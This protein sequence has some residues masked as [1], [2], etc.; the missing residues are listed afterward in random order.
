MDKDCI[1]V[2]LSSPFKEITG[3]R[4]W[5]LPTEGPLTVEQIL[6]HMVKEFPALGGFVPWVKDEILFWGHLIPMKD[7]AILKPDAEVWPGETIYL[8]PPLSGG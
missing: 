3:R 4:S 1:K 6:G 7:D 2:I 8:Y 5:E